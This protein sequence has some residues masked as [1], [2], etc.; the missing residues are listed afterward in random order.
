MSVVSPPCAVMS[1]QRGP[2]GRSWY[3]ATIAWELR[4]HMSG[5]VS[6]VSPGPG[7]RDTPWW[8]CCFMGCQFIT[9]MTPT[10]IIVSDPKI[11]PDL[12]VDYS[13]QFLGSCSSL[14]EFLQRVEM[15]WMGCITATMDIWFKILQSKCW[16]Y[17]IK[18]KSLNTKNSFKYDFHQLDS[19]TPTL[20]A[21]NCFCSEGQSPSSSVR[22]GQETCQRLSDDCR[23]F[24]LVLTHPFSYR[25]YQ[26]N[27]LW[28]SHDGALTGLNELENKSTMHFDLWS[29]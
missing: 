13:C 19:K 17:I 5:V 7:W 24:L 26:F 29:T 1:R 28:L 20:A 8:Q 27:S 6:N 4:A 14:G 25:N 21:C 9:F 11:W 3:F 16:W 23:L 18:V 10:Q 15:G 12:I 22:E 2:E